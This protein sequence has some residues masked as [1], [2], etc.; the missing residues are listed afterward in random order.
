[1]FI[2]LIELV[3]ESFGVRAYRQKLLLAHGRAPRP[4]ID[5]SVAWRL[6]AAA[7]A[8]AAGAKATEAKTGG[9]AAQRRQVDKR[10]SGLSGA[11]VFREIFYFAN[12]G[13]SGF[14]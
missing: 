11:C 10:S 1:V 6:T 7:F 3:D 9:I 4:W 14:R 8:R 12:P 13:G 5:G 2:F